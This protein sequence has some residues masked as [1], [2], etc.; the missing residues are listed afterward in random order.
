MEPTSGDCPSALM[1]TNLEDPNPSA[2]LRAR[3][4]TAAPKVGGSSHAT[5]G[6]GMVEIRKAAVE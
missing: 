4:T 5:L 1:R 6:T 2:R 3:E